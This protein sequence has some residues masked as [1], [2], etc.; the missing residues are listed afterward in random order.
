M[1]NGNMKTTL[2]IQL[3]ALSWHTY[4]KK[5]KKRNAT[6][7]CGKQFTAEHERSYHGT[8]PSIAIEILFRIAPKQTH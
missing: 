1:V 5:W 4:N 7:N 3:P 8:I 2:S 6:Q